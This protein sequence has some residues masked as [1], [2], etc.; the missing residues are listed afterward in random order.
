MIAS[1]TSRSAE[2]DA[3]RGAE[4]QPGGRRGAVSNASGGSSSRRA[5]PDAGLTL[6]SAAC[7]W[8]AGEPRAEASRE[9]ETAAQERSRVAVAVFRRLL[10]LMFVV[11]LRQLPSHFG[12][13]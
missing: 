2:R 8:R 7:S 6:R 3:Q 9:N 5:T 11:G 1:R 10:C 4:Y 13:F 12:Q